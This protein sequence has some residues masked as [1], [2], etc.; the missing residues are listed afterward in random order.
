[1]QSC[2]AVIVHSVLLEHKVWACFFQI[3]R[4]CRFLRLFFLLAFWNRRRGPEDGRIFVGFLENG[5]SN[6]SIKRR[7]FV[8]FVDR[9]HLLFLDSWACG[10][11]AERC[12]RGIL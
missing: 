12:Q 8:L 7:K 3:G 10:K 6:V 4:R 9:V 5:C 11:R 1:M 2:P